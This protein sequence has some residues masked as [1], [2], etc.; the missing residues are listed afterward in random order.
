MNSLESGFL[1]AE[2]PT[3]GDNRWGSSGKLSGSKDRRGICKGQPPV[4]GDLVGLLL[5]EPSK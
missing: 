3:D 1:L 2:R 4:G 5:E